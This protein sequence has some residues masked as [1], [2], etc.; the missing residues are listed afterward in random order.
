MF[1]SVRSS[2]KLNIFRDISSAILA[3]PTNMEMSYLQRARL[4]RKYT[5]AVPRYLT[6]RGFHV[7]IEPTE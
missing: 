2:T 7:I 3:H 1:S 5:A 4:R 6:D